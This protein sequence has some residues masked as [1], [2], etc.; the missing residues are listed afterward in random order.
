MQTATM[1][2]PLLLMKHHSVQHLQPNRIVLHQQM[3]KR[4]LLQNVNMKVKAVLR[5][6]QYI[7][8]MLLS[9]MSG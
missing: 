1:N 6:V 4:K 5:F 9:D 8:F 3:K 7:N 2:L